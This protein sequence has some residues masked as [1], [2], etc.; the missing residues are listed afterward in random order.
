M[1]KWNE[2]DFSRMSQLEKD[3]EHLQRKCTWE[4]KEMSK[5]QEKCKNF[6]R[7]REKKRLVKFTK[8]LNKIFEK[9][10]PK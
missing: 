1:E 2:Q 4:Q 3:I 7:N 8:N 6:Q 5:Y 10:P 9:D